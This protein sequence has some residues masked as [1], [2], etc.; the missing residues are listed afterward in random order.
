LEQVVEPEFP[1]DIDISK[2]RFDVNTQEDF[3]KIAGIYG[4]F[5][6][7]EFSM[8]DLLEQAHGHENRNSEHISAR[9]RLI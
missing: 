5:G 8:K 6:N 9:Q 2:F 7:N 3:N 4:T 1:L